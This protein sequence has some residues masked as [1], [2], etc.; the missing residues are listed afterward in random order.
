MPHSPQP[1]ISA[2]LAHL[3]FGVTAAGFGLAAL[4]LLQILVWAFVHFTDVRTTKLEGPAPQQSFEVVEGARPEQVGSLSGV[5]PRGNAGASLGGDGER[6]G[7]GL[8][9]APASAAAAQPVNPNLVESA[10]DRM[11]RAAA[12]VVQTAGIVAAA[13]FLLLLLQAVAVAGGGAVPG[14]E[15]A[16][17]ASTLGILTAL[18]SIPLVGLVP[19]APFPGVFQSYDT[20]VSTSVGYRAG[21]AQAPGPIGF[22]AAN[23]VLPIIL[24]TL[25]S[26][27]VLRFRAGIERGLISTTVSEAHERLEREIRSRKNLGE[28]ASSRAAG[29]LNATLGGEPVA[30]QPVNL[31]VNPGAGPGGIN[32]SHPSPHGGGYGQPQGPAG[33]M[34]HAA[35]APP[36]SPSHGPQAPPASGHQ[37]MGAAPYAAG[38]H[39]EGVTGL[40]PRSILPDSPPPQDGRRPV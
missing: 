32:A 40:P 18:L 11:L 33:S 2:A 30:Q 29:A 13:L 3:R 20:L 4:L 36:A 31:N 26:V 22:Y 23:V 24:A 9:N 28:L 15:M 6:A 17:T 10:A 7:G 21:D 34:D 38:G 5:S 19:D 12:A 8:A 16:V 1:H 39:D 14:V 35:P 25:A 37:G 27:A